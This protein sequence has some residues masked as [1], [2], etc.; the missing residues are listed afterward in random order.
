LPWRCHRRSFDGLRRQR[1]DRA[2]S[3]DGASD[4]IF[5]LSCL[6]RLLPNIG[7]ED[8]GTSVILFVTSR[9]LFRELLEHVADPSLTLLDPYGVV[10]PLGTDSGPL[11]RFRTYRHSLRILVLAHP[12][13]RQNRIDRSD[14]HGSECRLVEHAHLLS[15]KLAMGQ[16]KGGE[17]PWLSL[18]DFTTEDSELQDL[19]HVFHHKPDR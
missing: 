1:H 4:R 10:R 8:P 16:R 15:Q 11:G 5:S 13:P 14:A 17:S 6:F 12:G 3:L 9:L 19:L 2:P 18:Q 7:P